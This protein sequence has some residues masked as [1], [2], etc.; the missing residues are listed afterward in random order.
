MKSVSL[1][2]DYFAVVTEI[3]VQTAPTHY[4]VAVVVVVG[5]LQ[6]SWKCFQWN[7]SELQLLLPAVIGKR[8]K[9]TC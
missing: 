8:K 1:I 2:V 6:S 7:Y 3:P 5:C 4:L 9:K